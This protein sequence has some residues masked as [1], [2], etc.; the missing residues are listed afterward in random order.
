MSFH[1]HYLIHTYV[2]D[3]LLTYIL[4]N[5]NIII[6]YLNKTIC[7]GIRRIRKSLVMFLKYVFLKLEK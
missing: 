1:H 2:F 5:N 6:K 3:L 7:G 4:N